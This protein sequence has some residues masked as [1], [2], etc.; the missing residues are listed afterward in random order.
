MKHR[1]E[2]ELD[3]APSEVMAFV[4]AWVKLARDHNVWAEFIAYRCADPKDQVILAAG[5]SALSIT[6]ES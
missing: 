2:M 4:N 5:V 6:G 1:V 3:C